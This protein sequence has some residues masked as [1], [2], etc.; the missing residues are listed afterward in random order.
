MKVWLGEGAGRGAASCSAFSEIFRQFAVPI[1]C[2]VGH[3][4]LRRDALLEGSAAVI[5]LVGLHTHPLVDADDAREALI[6]G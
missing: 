5:T 2:G 6:D 1:P 4:P 3:R